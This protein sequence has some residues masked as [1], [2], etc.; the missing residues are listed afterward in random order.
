M[1]IVSP[2]QAEEPLILT[3]DIG[4]SV[5]RTALFDR[6]GRAVGGF[7]AR[8]MHEIR[9]TSQGASETDPDSLL[10]VVFDCLDRVLATAGHFSNKIAGVA[11]CT[12]VSNI[13]GIDKSKRA[14]MP[15]T[16]YADTRAAAEVPGLKADFDEAAFHD[17]T[18]CRFHPS[19]LPA[20]F[21]WLARSQPDLF[22][23]VARW[24]SIGEYLELKLFG[25]TAVSY[26]V[27]S[28]TGLL[29]R[30]SLSWDKTLLSGLPVQIEQISPLT[31]VN[32]PRRGLRPEFAARWPILRD[33]PWFPAVGD[34]ATANIGSGCIS[35]A[36][37]ALSGGTTSAV[38]AILTNPPE[39]LP[40]GLWSYRVDG[41]RSLLGGALSEGGSVFGWMKS[42][43]HLENLSGIEELLA[44]MEPDGHGLTVL[45]FLA[46]ERSPGWAGHARGT[47]HG[48]SLATTPLDILRAGLEAVAYRIALVFDLLRK[49]LPADPQVV[50]SGGALLSSPAWLQIMTD[51]LGRPVFVSGVQEASGRGAALLALEALGVLPDLEAAPDFV[52]AVYQPNFSRHAR[53]QKAMI[54]QQKLYEKLV[55]SEILNPES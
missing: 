33:L 14:V 4:T 29:N 49:V 16:T 23:R 6:L 37:V 18:G 50:A 2:G 22:H 43:L 1:S 8:Q 38:R 10:E 15:L 41:R 34:G 30:S 27:A 25:E 40:S 20:R 51:V 12:F 52:A 54:R 42:T 35:P 21:R 19:Y 44:A 39:H 47:I 26:S 9:T 28:W 31:D 46:G 17:R 7:E 32:I 45:P 11:S 53:Y 5:V 13:L 36:R 24:V 55:K 48:L 3:I